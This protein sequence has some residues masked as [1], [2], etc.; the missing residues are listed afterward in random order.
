MTA[1]PEEASTGNLE[2]Y[3]VWEVNSRGKRGRKSGLLSWDEAQILKASLPTITGRVRC[4]YEV[5]AAGRRLEGLE[6]KR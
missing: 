5:E 6:E 1:Q 4:T 3:I 2:A